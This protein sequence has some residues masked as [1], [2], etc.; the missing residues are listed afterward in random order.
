MGLIA[1][2]LT[3]KPDHEFHLDNVSFE[4]QEGQLYTFLGRTLSGKTT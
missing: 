1:Q 2:N 3:L 4:M